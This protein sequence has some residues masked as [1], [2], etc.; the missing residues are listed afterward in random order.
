LIG[1]V[2]PKISSRIVEQEKTEVAA[3]FQGLEGSS[4]PSSRGKEL[5]REKSCIQPGFFPNYLGGRSKGENCCPFLGSPQ[6]REPPDRTTLFFFLPKGFSCLI[7]RN[8]CR[9]SLKVGRSRHT[10]EEGKGCD[11]HHRLEMQSRGK[12]E[13][14]YLRELCVYLP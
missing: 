10:P 3:E 7:M 14:T 12:K 5:G 2:V 1:R 11:E 9:G 4:G 13:I 8:E 6:G